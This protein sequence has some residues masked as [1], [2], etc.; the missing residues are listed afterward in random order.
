MITPLIIIWLLLL[1]YFFLPFVWT[2]HQICVVSVEFFFLSFF[3]LLLTDCS[4]HNDSSIF[5]D[6]AKVKHETVSSQTL[7]DVRLIKKCEIQIG[8][9]NSIGSSSSMV[10]YILFTWNQFPNTNFIFS[11]QFW[12][13]LLKRFDKNQW[14]LFA[15]TND[16]RN[17]FSSH[18]YIYRPIIYLIWPIFWRVA[19]PM[20]NQ[21]N[22]Q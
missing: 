17:P 18:K 11:R 9:R 2:P 3:L 7:D 4:V 14:I 6:D 1:F 12:H 21:K 20:C 5:D 16:D 10:Y 13:L 22:M 8:Q 15:T 19:K